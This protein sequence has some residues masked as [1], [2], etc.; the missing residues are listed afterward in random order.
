[1]VSY[2]QISAVDTLLSL[3]ND[4]LYDDD[5][6]ATIRS[7]NCQTVFFPNTPK[8]GIDGAYFVVLNRL[9]EFSWSDNK[10]I[11]IASRLTT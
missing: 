8:V 7:V 6:T 5:Q 11:T 2:F 1:M 10:E 3:F 9:N 4:D